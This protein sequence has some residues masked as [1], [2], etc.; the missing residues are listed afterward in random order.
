MVT[1][2]EPQQM[3]AQQRPPGEIE[4]PQGFLGG[5]A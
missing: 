1:G 5:K 2:G 3:A 4:R